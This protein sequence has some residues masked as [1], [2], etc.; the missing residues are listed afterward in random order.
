MASNSKKRIGFVALLL[1][2]LFV[3]AM[4]QA[5]EKTPLTQDEILSLVTASR[6]G[7]LSAG[8][9]VELIGQRGVGFAISDVFLLELNVR[10]ADEAIIQT[11]RKLKDAGKDFPSSTVSTAGG[12]TAA[13]TPASTGNVPSEAEWPAF[14]EAVR[15]KAL[16]YSEDLPN[17]ICTQVTQRSIR[18]FPQGWQPTDNFV[19]DLSYYDQ[20][21]HYKIISVSNRPAS[22]KK[23]EDLKGAWSTGEFGTTLHSIFDPKSNASFRLE[24]GEQLNGRDAVRFSYMVPLETSDSAITYEE[25]SHKKKTIITAYRGRCWVDPESHTVIKVEDKALN[26]PADFPI[27]RAERVIEYDLADIAGRKY[28]LPLRA[29]MTMVEGA[30]NY[31]SRNVIEFKRYRKFEAEV[32]LVPD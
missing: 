29:E 2:L 10:G 30:R 20:K 9:V 26:I 31:H 32:K 16:S 15:A 22:E 13:S 11:L 5:Q 3:I 18:L 25:E 7:E 23:M 17:F 19:A 4:A 28:W 14:L 1:L 27:T 24:G 6:L 21:E 8:R 12:A